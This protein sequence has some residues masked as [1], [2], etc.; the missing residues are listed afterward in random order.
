M[1]DWVS[2]FSRAS[3]VNVVC[4]HGSKSGFL[5]NFLRIF[6][7]RHF[8]NLVSFVKKLRLTVFNSDLDILILAI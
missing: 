3:R 4:Q 6:L 1:A 7:K 5:M 2:A 8:L